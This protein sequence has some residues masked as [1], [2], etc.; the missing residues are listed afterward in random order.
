MLRTIKGGEWSTICLPFAMT[1]DEVTTAFGN[2]VQL[3]DFIDYE[4]K[5][6]AEENIVKLT[7]N[8]DN[9]NPANGMEANY[10]YLIKTSDEIAEFTAK[11]VI[12]PDEEGAGVE[13]D[14]GKTGSRREVYGTF[15]GTFH[16][17][18]VVPENCLFISGNQFWYSKG[19]T[20]M[21]AFRAYLKFVDVL[22]SVE[23]SDSRISVNF[24]HSTGI[25]DINRET[26]GNNRYYD[27]Q[28]RRVAKPGKGLFVKDGK[29]VVIK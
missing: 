19:L 2:D 14:N 12:E 5:E 7:V 10:P 4:A 9:L 24:G 25:N 8:F 3:A 23:G 21:K 1:G 29:E 6:D 22:T 20:K 16:S 13:Y 26:T 11:S 27:L 18:T 17:E 15:Q 28:G